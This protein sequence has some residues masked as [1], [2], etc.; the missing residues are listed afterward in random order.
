[1]T[2]PFALPLAWPWLFETT[3]KS[4]ANRLRC[5]T[6]LS[7][8]RMHSSRDKAMRRGPSAH[9]VRQTLSERDEAI[10]RS[11]E[12][13]RYMSSGQLELLHFSDQASQPTAARTCRRVLSR[14]TKLGLLWQLERRIGGVRAGS[15][16]YVYGLGALGY[17][18]L[19]EGSP[20]RQN[21]PSTQFLDHTLAITG[22]AVDLHVQERSGSLELLEVATEP[23]CWRP[24]TVG[25]E[26][27]ETL[28]PDL[29]VSL[30]S[31]GYEYHWFVEV[32]LATHSAASVLR[33]CAIYQKYWQ[34]GIE[35]D[36]SG[37]F[38]K[39]LWVTP[40]TRR[41]AL[42]RRS[43]SASRQLHPDLFQVCSREAAVACLTGEES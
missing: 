11:V 16:S 33:K 35:Q 20:P 31:G 39:V 5:A 8:S 6:T 37:V 42:I 41:Q 23:K 9:G 24:F 34:T 1:M 17:R 3:C 10:I 14:L 32:D 13:Y 43:I 18:I 25:L 27:S 15:A 12:D 38:P 2:L 26:S 36:R 29:F 19:H 21:E 28:K 7:L 22:L 4:E 40:Y 30:R